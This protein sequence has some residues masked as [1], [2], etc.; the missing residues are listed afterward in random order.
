[1]NVPLSIVLLLVSKVAAYEV[2]YAVNFGGDAAT[3]SNGIN[4]EKDYNKN[5][6]KQTC[7]ANITTLGVAKIDEII[8]RSVRHS[9]QRLEIAAIPDVLDDGEYLINFK[10]GECWSIKNGV[11]PINIMINTYHTVTVEVHGKDGQGVTLDK[12]FY[13]NICDKKLNFKDASSPF[14]DGKLT[15]DLA[16]KQAGKTV[17]ISG[18]VLI[19]LTGSPVPNALWPSKSPNKPFVCRTITEVYTNLQH[20]YKDLS[21]NMSA[22]SNDVTVAIGNSS[23]TI[24]QQIVKAQ[25]NQMKA[26]QGQLDSKLSSLMV[27]MKHEMRKQDAIQQKYQSELLNKISTNNDIQKSALTQ[28]G[29]EIQRILKNQRAL[30]IKLVS[31]FDALKVTVR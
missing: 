24:K 27:E 5:G 2:I 11:R 31:I 4:Y 28:T 1:M 18:L 25:M 19:K 3:D 30:S 10:F 14:A 6:F 13:F 17:I 26:N 22:M 8:Y 20:H 9:K 21:S 12:S 15:I 16:P 23:N 29:V 7:P